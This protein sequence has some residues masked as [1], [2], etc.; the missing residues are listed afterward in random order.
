MAAHLVSSFLFHFHSPFSSLSVRSTSS[1]TT[2]T[3]KPESQASPAT[4]D[5]ESPSPG[6]DHPTFHTTASQ[7]ATTISSDLPPPSSPPGPA[8]GETAARLLTVAGSLDAFD[9]PC[10]RWVSQHQHQ[11]NTHPKT[12]LFLVIVLIYFAHA[13][14]RVPFQEYLFAVIHCLKRSYKLSLK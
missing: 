12:S 10:R 5:G 11:V 13:I 8:A 2:S 3:N 1:A 7:K 6:N 4:T 9:Q 14:Y